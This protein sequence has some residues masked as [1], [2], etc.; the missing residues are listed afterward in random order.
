MGFGEDRGGGRDG[1]GEGGEKEDEGTAAGGHWEE[2]HLTE[3]FVGEGR[4]PG[5]ATAGTVAGA[6]VK[7]KNGTS[8]DILG[9]ITI[10]FWGS[11]GQFARRGHLTSTDGA[12]PLNVISA[13]PA[14]V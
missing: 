6:E 8:W 10:L 14:R 9:L 7:I 12:A 5:F 1:N 2:R 4:G 3:G 13:T 11:G